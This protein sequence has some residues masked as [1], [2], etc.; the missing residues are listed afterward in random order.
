M[1]L[2]EKWAPADPAR[3]ALQFCSTIAGEAFVPK[4]LGTGRQQ[5]RNDSPSKAEV[6][7]ARERIGEQGTSRGRRKWL[8]DILRIPEHPFNRVN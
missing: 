8:K 4:R 6:R 5:G 2:N 1:C 7:Q 3:P